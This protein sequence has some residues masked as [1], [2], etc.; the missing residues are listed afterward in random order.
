MPY[1][2][3]DRKKEWERLHRTLAP[4]RQLRQIEADQQHDQPEVPEVS[5]GA[6]AFCG[7]CVGRTRGSAWQV[8][9]A[10]FPRQLE[11]RR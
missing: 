9:T 6:P 11:L 8:K 10:M 3:P 2:D 1:K 5:I 7:Q 4:R